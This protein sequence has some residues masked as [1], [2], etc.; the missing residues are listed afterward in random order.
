MEAM[1]SL[2]V[3][4]MRFEPKSPLLRSAI[5]GAA[6]LA[7]GACAHGPSIAPANESNAVRVSITM[8]ESTIVAQLDDT[9]TARSFVALLPLRLPL[10]DHAATE[11]V[12]TLPKKLSLEG[13]P[14]GADADA[15]DLAYY[16]PLGNFVM[17]YRDPGY[18]PGL[19]RLGRIQMGAETLQSASGTVT[20]QAVN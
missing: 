12:A 4:L 9:P 2:Y 8:D 20:I 3:S 6:V 1:L 14:A 19:V 13:A 11:K 16:A 17:Y 15:Y 10:R 18:F 5:A 7:L